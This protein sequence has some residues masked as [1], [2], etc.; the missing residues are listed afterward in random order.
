MEQINDNY[1]AIILQCANISEM[2]FT[3]VQ[4]EQN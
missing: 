1:A 4:I 2:N 3:D